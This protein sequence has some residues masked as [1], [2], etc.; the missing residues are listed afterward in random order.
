M[1]KVGFEPVV[2]QKYEMFQT[3][4]NRAVSYMAQL[5]TMK[6]TTLFVVDAPDLGRSRIKITVDSSQNIPIVKQV[7]N[8]HG[9]EVVEATYDKKI[10][11]VQL[12]YNGNTSFRVDQVTCL[13]LKEFLL[14][15]LTIFERSHGYTM[16]THASLADRYCAYRKVA[17]IRPVDSLAISQN[18][19]IKLLPIT[20]N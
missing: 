8:A 11:N 7:F 20:D 2:G 4:F 12:N 15:V 5:D 9:F 1:K 6:D 3:L 13:Y 14:N 18:T 17:K 19:L 16:P 10:M